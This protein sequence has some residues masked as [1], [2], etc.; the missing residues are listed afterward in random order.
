MRKELT[1]D[2]PKDTLTI[3][4]ERVC[5]QRP[6]WRSKEIKNIC[7]KMK[8]ISQMNIVLLCYSCV[9]AA[10]N[11]AATAFL[12]KTGDANTWVRKTKSLTQFGSRPSWL[13][14]D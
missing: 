1:R 3:C 7:L 10:M 11:N 8:F 12:A 2:S 14:L 13:Q 9:M 6:C 4:R 5:A